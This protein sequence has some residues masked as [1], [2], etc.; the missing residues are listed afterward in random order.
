M[1]AITQ[2]IAVVALLILSE[3]AAIAAAKKIGGFVRLVD[4]N[5]RPVGDSIPGDM[6]IVVF[7]ATDD[8]FFCT[9]MFV[10]SRTHELLPSELSDYCASLPLVAEM[11]MWPDKGWTQYPF[12]SIAACTGDSCSVTVTVVIL[13]STLRDRLL[14]QGASELKKGNRSV[15]VCYLRKASLGSPEYTAK[16]TELLATTNAYICP[17]D[18]NCEQTWPGH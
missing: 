3:S 16:S 17:P 14:A 7:G 15:A 6:K 1:R 5:S 10:G 13:P 11:T 4:E 2:L 18:T 9:Y 12:P 8:H